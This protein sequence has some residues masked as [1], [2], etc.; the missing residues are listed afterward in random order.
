MLYSDFSAMYERV[1]YWTFRC[2]LTS[3]D[4]F[5]IIAV[6]SNPKSYSDSSSG[7]PYQRIMIIPFL[8]ECLRFWVE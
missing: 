7:S 5:D 1:V 4:F 2:S 6:N 8:E 3:I